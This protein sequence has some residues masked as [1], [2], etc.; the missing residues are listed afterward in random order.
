M[1]NTTYQVT[2]STDGRHSIT[3]TSDDEAAAE[4]AVAWASDLFTHFPKRRTSPSRADEL[5]DEDIDAQ[6]PPICAVHQLP[7]VRVESRRGAFWS[8]H[9][10][11]PDGSFCAYRP[12]RD[13]RSV[14]LDP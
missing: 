12:P 4:A 9:Q 1:A 7:M 13:R 3:I 5:T 11:L 2:L 10:R 8:C 14:D 6:T